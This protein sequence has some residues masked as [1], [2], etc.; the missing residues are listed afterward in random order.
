MQ[1][2]FKLFLSATFLIAVSALAVA[3]K[4]NVGVTVKVQ[5]EILRQLLRDNG[6]AAPS[7]ESWDD[8]KIDQPAREYIS[9]N[10]VPLSRDKITYLVAGNRS[11]FYGAH[12][13]MFW[14]YE[15]TAS[16]YRQIDDLG[17]YYDVKVL[18]TS[19][20]GFRDLG[21]AYISGAGSVLDTCKL[22]FN[23]HRYDADRCESSPI[24]P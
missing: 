9:V 11:P 13:P 1:T 24:K 21:T 5:N 18:P 6:A 4:K 17:A 12:A 23:G 8:I 15:K 20:N 14:I 19:H 2:V 16:G 10:R 3:Q 22:V 7:P